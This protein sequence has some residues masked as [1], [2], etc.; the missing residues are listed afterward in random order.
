VNNRLNGRVKKGRKPV[1]AQSM[2]FEQ[3]VR[4]KGRK[5]RSTSTVRVVVTRCSLPGKMRGKV[6]AGM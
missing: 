3:K 4:K 5:R 1:A 6:A 2:S